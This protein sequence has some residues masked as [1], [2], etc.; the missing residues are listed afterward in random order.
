DFGRQFEGHR[1]V[2][3][4]VDRGGAGVDLLAIDA[5]GS[6]HFRSRRHAALSP[7]AVQ[8]SLDLIA[9]PVGVAQKDEPALEPGGA[10]GAVVELAFSRR[11]AVEQI[12]NFR[13]VFPARLPIR[14]RPRKSEDAILAGDHP[15]A[16]YVA[17]AP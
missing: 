16:D 11:V 10:V 6:R 8:R 9:R 13:G 5:A 15:A 4:L 2:A 1:A 7:L 12:R 3:L 14:H 17:F